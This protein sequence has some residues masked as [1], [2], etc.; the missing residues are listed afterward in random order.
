MARIFPI[1][2]A[3][4]N[5]HWCALKAKCIDVVARR[6]TVNSPFHFTNHTLFL[7]ASLCHHIVVSPAHKYFLPFHFA[8]IIEKSISGKMKTAAQCMPI[9]GIWCLS[10]RGIVKH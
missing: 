7:F 10:A 6:D 9:V 2:S 3:T 8:R 4:E 5:K 1:P